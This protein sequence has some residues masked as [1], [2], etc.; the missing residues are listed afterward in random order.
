M[1]SA[2]QSN[3]IEHEHSNNKRSY[4]LSEYNNNIPI[5][6]R[7]NDPVLRTHDFTREHTKNA[8]ELDHDIRWASF[9]L[10]ARNIFK[11]V[12]VRPFQGFSKFFKTAQ[13]IWDK[14]DKQ[15]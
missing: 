6:S 15:T 8:T 1:L 7:A 5:E 12:V 4:E 13:S 3:S 2:L 10:I 14:G 11:D 9:G